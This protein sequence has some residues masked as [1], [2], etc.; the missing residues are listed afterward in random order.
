MSLHLSDCH[1]HTEYSGDAE[2]TLSWVVSQ[3]ADL[4]LSGLCPTE[5]FD[6]GPTDPRFSRIDLDGMFARHRRLL[7]E[8][9]PVVLGIGL[10]VTYRPGLEDQIR[11]LLITRRF[12]LVIGSVHD[13]E[14]LYL[15]EWL[16]RFPRGTQPL[17]TLL[18]PFI[19]LTAR[20]IQTGL[21]SVVGHIDYVK[22]Y[23]PGLSGAEFLSMFRDRLAGSLEMLLSQGG[24]L[25]LN[26][27]GLRHDCREPYPS[28]ELMQLYR[29]LGGEAVT[30]GSDAHSSAHYRV[31]V[32]QGVE[33]ARSAGLHVIDWRSLPAS[34]SSALTAGD[35]EEK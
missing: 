34:G 18:L 16:G 4:G 30:V 35:G 5:H 20:M 14:G 32:S 31:P 29:A 28:R 9:L 12:D 10:E 33:I 7:A 24:V 1:L 22:R 6:P 27:S 19:D 11:Q 21:F 3:A 17:R 15:R 8:D 23:V 2:L 13:L 25:E 26:L